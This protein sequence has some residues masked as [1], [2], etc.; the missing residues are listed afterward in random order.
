[1]TPDSFKALISRTSPSGFISPAIEKVPFSILPENEVLIKVKLSSLNYK[2]ALSASGK[3]NVTRNY[4]HI[5]GIDASGTVISDTSGQFKSGQEVIV[6]GNDLGTNTFGGFGEYI[7]V[8]ADWVVALPD[9]LTPEQAMISGTAGFTAAYGIER[10]IRELITPEKGKILVTGAS[11]GVGSFAIFMLSQLGYS[12]TAMTGKSEQ[13]DFLKSLGAGNILSR[14]EFLG[15][16]KSPLL[17]RKWAGAIETV[18]G[19]I[20]DIAL[21]QTEND[22]AVACCGNILSQTLETSVYPFILRGV[23]LLGISSA[24]CPK[25]IRLNIWKTISE[26]DFKKLPYNYY[27]TIGLEQLPNEIEKILNGKQVGRIVVRHS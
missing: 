26:L 8:P 5:P 19:E 21:R 1:M 24:L 3:N 18:G 23:S 14:N 11:G 16:S 2:D 17:P 15:A 27:R 25:S 20:L 9:S 7:R 22:G 12:V 4:P 10:L 6:T 13:H